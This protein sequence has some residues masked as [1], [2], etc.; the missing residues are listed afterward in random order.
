MKAAG[1]TRYGP[2]GVDRVE[3]VAKPTAGDR[4]VLVKVHVATVNRTDCGFRSAKPFIVRFFSGL[5]RP[6]VTVLGTEFAG[7]LGAVGRG[8]TAL[9]SATECS[10]TAR[11]C[12]GLS[13]VRHDS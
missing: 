2:P 12:G 4:E 1:Y 5:V 13:A 3:E 7:V 6:K 9:Q 11:T 10:A 8:V